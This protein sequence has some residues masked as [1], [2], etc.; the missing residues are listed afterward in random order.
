MIISN[1]NKLW[2]YFLVYL[3]LLLGA[4][5][6]FRHLYNKYTIPIYLL[7]LLVTVVKRDIKL[8]YDVLIPTCAMIYLILLTAILTGLGSFDRYIYCI[9]S[10]LIAYI[11]TQIFCYR[12][13]CIIFSD[14]IF[15]IC[16]VS[17]IGW[18]LMKVAPT[19]IMLFPKIIN[20]SRIEAYFLGLAVIEAPT[21]IGYQNRIQGIF[22]E[23]GAF[24]TMIVFAILCD[25]FVNENGNKKRY[26]VYFIAI[27]LTFSTTGYICILML[28]GV[29]CMKKKTYGSGFIVFL[30]T[31]IG[32]GLLL[33]LKDYLSKFMYYS[34]FTKLEAVIK[35]TPG[36]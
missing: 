7:L 26:V 10:L 5:F 14:I 13:F 18:L 19:V 36:V 25:W 6:V 8:K 24:Q 30:S 21:Y 29:F 9:I 15:V 4:G 35:Y 1:G 31:I 11:I 17:I 20:S 27:V 12:N 3:L 28:L 32:V 33:N 2:D 34:I 23:P 16:I 22:W